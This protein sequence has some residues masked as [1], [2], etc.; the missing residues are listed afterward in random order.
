MM[1]VPKKYILLEKKMRFEGD[2]L[3]EVGIGG[4]RLWGAQTQRHLRNFGSI[5]CDLV[6]IEVVHA[7]AV[8]KRA[9]AVVNGEMGILDKERMRV[10]CDVSEEVESG[11]LDEHF[12]ALVWQLGSGTHTN[13]NLN[14]VISNRCNQLLGKELGA[15][16]PVHPNDH[17]NASQ[18]SND[19]FPAAVNIAILQLA[20]NTLLPG[21]GKLS[22]ELHTKVK[23]FENVVTIGRTHLMDA[24]P[25]T[26][27]QVA[28]ISNWV[29]V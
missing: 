18:S 20:Q 5:G 10:I 29:L 16:D 2:T 17:V 21:M 15:K 3:G 23:E 26:L 7:L 22:K 4:D 25:M 27:G 19:T 8:I 13:M 28:H 12:P 6:P 9:C 1:N 24:L 14:E 11:V